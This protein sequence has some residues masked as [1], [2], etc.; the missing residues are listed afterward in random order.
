MAEDADAGV[1][2]E[3]AEALARIDGFLETFG[4]DPDGEDIGVLLD[5]EYLG[6]YRTLVEA[7][8]RYMGDERSGDYRFDM[9][10][11]YEDHSPDWILAGPYRVLVH[12]VE[13]RYPAAEVYAAEFDVDRYV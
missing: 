5:Y 4:L 9:S 2:G 12:A 6:G 3:V 8:V 10:L 1:D 11:T 13:E 7:N